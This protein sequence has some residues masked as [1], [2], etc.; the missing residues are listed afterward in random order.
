MTTPPPPAYVPLTPR[1]WDVLR[2]YAQRLEQA[3]IAAH[4]GLSPNTVKAVLYQLH[5]RLPARPSGM[6]RRAWMR[7]WCRAH[8]PDAPLSVRHSAA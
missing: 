1:Q 8:D 3:E 4:L 2:L 5:L 6:T 7:A